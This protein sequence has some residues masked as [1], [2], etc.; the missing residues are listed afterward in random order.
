MKAVA[1]PQW[2][3]LISSKYPC[4]V[5]Q[6]YSLVFILRDFVPISWSCTSIHTFVCR[7]PFGDVIALGVRFQQTQRCCLGIRVCL[8]SHVPNYRGLEWL[9]PN[10]SCAAS[11][12]FFVQWYSTW[13]I[14]TILKQE[15]SLQTCFLCEFPTGSTPGRLSRLEV[16]DMST[17]FCSILFY[18]TCSLGTENTSKR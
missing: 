2:H 3:P 8:F 14:I 1:V 18:L 11:F 5:A 10:S 15:R 17:L 7:L 4:C 16:C 6:P 9:G 12:H 13:W